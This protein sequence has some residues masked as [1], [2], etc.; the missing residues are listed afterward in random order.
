M[1]G[2]G[3]QL[4]KLSQNK[5]GELFI[6]TQCTFCQGQCGGVTAK[7]HCDESTRKINKKI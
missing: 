2:I 3:L 6:E 4:G 1:I 5:K 7:R